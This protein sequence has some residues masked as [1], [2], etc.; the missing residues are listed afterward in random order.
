MNRERGEFRCTRSDTRFQEFTAIHWR[1]AT[2]LTSETF[3][4]TLCHSQARLYTVI[5]P[6]TR[7]SSVGLP[8]IAFETGL[9]STNL[10]DYP[11]Y[12][13]RLV[14]P[15]ERPRLSASEWARWRMNRNHFPSIPRRQ[16]Q[17]CVKL[18]YGSNAK[19]GQSIPVETKSRRAFRH[20]IGSYL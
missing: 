8:G 11:V 13:R 14:W 17:A 3:C 18:A 7:F 20:S 4:L 6:K 12:F 10:G 5:S 19:N 1:V 9:S 15:M 2:R 16:M